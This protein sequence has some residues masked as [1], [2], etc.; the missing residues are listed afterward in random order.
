MDLPIGASNTWMQSL[1]RLFLSHNQIT[2][3][4]RN[5]TDLAH[6]TILDLSHNRITS[7][8]PTSDWSGNRLNKLNLSFNQLNVLTHLLSKEEQ[9]A[10][11]KEEHHKYASVSMIG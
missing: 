3:I 4:S 1:E 11:E 6:L 9:A 5:I 7:L 10:K 2:E 8:P